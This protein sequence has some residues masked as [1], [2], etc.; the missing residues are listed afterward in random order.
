MLKTFTK[1]TSLVVLMGCL[2]SA[3]TVKAQSLL[4]IDIAQQHIKQNHKKWGLSAEDV[5]DLHLSA[6]YTDRLTGKTR[7][8]FVQRYQGVEI[9][10]A[11]LNIGVSKDG[12]A[13]NIGH[14]FIPELAKKANAPHS[15]IAPTTA[16]Y[17]VASKLGLKAGR[18]PLNVEKAKEGKYFEYTS[19]AIAQH[20]IR[21]HLC[22]HPTEDGKL[23]LAWDIVLQPTGTLD[24]WRYRID[25]NTG[26]VLKRENMALYSSYG[27]APANDCRQ[28][29]PRSSVQ[30]ER[31][32]AAS[33]LLMAP[34]YNAFEFP[35]ESPNHGS[36][37]LINDPANPNAS[38]FGWHDT[39]GMAGDEYTIT[40]GNN[41]HAYEDRDDD[42]LSDDNEP[43]GGMNMVF[44]TPYDP[45]EEP[46][47]HIDAGVI[48]LF[49]AV[50]FMHD[51]A[52]EYGFTEEV[53]NHQQNNYGNGG[54]GGDPILARSQAGSL[55]KADGTRDVNN[56]TYLP[57]FDGGTSYISMFVWTKGFAANDF[58]K[59]NEPA[60]VAGLYEAGPSGANWDWGS[61]I[62][63]NP[64]TGEVVLVDDERGVTTDACQD[65]ANADE[66]NGKIAL[67]DRGSCEF[68]FKAKAA[69]DAGAIGVMICNVRGDGVITMAPGAVGNDVTIPV[70]MLGREDCARIRVFAGDGLSITFEQPSFPGPEELDGSFDNGI[71]AHEYG[72]GI[73]NRLTG[74]PD[75]LCLTIRE[76]DAVIGEQAGE[77]W[78]DFFTLVTTTNADS[79]GTDIRGIGTYPSRE[80]TDGKGFRPLPYTTD[81]SVNDA[82]YGDIASLP[83]PHG[84]GF[85]FCTMLWDMYWQF[86]ELYGFDADI[87]N[88]DS[89]NSRAILLVMEGLKN[90]PCFPG[91][92]DS[93]DAIIQADQDLYDGAHQE[94]IWRVFADR[95]LGFS[96]DQGAVNNAGDGIE[97]FDMPP[98]FVKEIKISKTVTPLIDAGG[99]ITISIT[100]RN[101]KEETATGLVVTDDIVSGSNYINGSIDNGLTADVSGDM[102]SVEIPDVATGGEYTFSYRLSTDASKSSIKYFYDPVDPDESP[103]TWFDTYSIEGEEVSQVGWQ[104]SDIVGGFIGDHAWFAKDSA[105]DTR[106][107]LFTQDPIEIIGSKP[108][109]RFY[110]RYM[111]E[112]GFDGGVV[113]LT[114]DED[115]FDGE[116][117]AT[118]NIMLRN[119]YIGPI[120][121]FTF[122]QENFPAYWGSSSNEW[123][124]TYVSLNRYKDGPMNIRFQFGTDDAA[125]LDDPEAGWL[126]D[127]IEIM[128]M[129]NYNGEACVTSDDNDQACARADGGGTIV[130]SKEGTVS[131]D[132]PD[133]QALRVRAFPNPTNEQL[134]ITI[135]TDQYERAT[136][137]L[138]TADGRE[139][140]QRTVELSAQVQSY[141]MDVESFPAGMYLLRI[142]TDND[143][144]IRKVMKQ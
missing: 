16:V 32:Q 70:L 96:A 62:T 59:V 38:P 31:Q 57:S 135:G 143:V 35:V 141:Q 100:V 98:Q 75:Q 139:M 49:Y 21:T 8:F 86:V 47:Q 121:F 56:A 45:T 37:S 53:G 123:V 87:S 134:N 131:T 78:S 142:Q 144:I 5:S 125:D 34:T 127:E 114:D 72:H 136:M 111:T 71:I 43:D 116:Y 39:D 88:K 112:A 104:V 140:I 17:T 27:R 110:H 99:E 65:I 36:R 97:A 7:F 138:L 89:G 6:H 48:N 10:N 132:N 126:I 115:S 122:V 15:S 58:I 85:V 26:S 64:I 9:V 76:G 33:S 41:V 94:M 118:G 22:Y 68:G 2:V 25:A 12:K 119:G 51:F 102:L 107:A 130:Q 3:V 77:G 124:D 13:S 129:V 105:V 60:S 67:I 50:N 92:V 28:E 11:V 4:P 69:Q 24:K 90:Q 23:K 137:S 113:E 1:W 109:L 55:L 42:N 66:I 46:E 103:D 133:L 14:R 108:V 44:D 83:V 120:S 40:R 81:K 63:Q 29:D 128:D 106:Q 19:K 61:D 101:D 20:N 93:R 84:V 73:S 95:G 117:D 74:G 18:A 30:T 79:K 91:F 54:Q 80:P 52:Y 82:T